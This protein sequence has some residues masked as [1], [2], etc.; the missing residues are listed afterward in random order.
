MPPKSLL[1]TLAV[2]VVVFVIDVAGWLK[3]VSAAS[4]GAGLP[5][6]SMLY[7]ASNVAVLTLHAGYNLVQ[8]VTSS[9]Q[10]RAAAATAAYGNL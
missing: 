6:A 9:L 5:S 10:A 4:Y 7:F 3:M 8:W 2:K 1:Q